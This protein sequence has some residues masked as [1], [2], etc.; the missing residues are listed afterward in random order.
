MTV[1]EIYT[2]A[3]GEVPAEVLEQFP[4][5]QAVQRD[6][7]L[8]GCT[9]VVLPLML[10]IGIIAFS[11]NAKVAVVLFVLSLGTWLAS[12]LNESS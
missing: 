2:E 3:D 1:H 9:P 4:V 10:V 5:S 7:D 11:P 8:D 12:K 6:P